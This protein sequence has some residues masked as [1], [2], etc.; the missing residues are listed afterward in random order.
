MSSPSRK[1]SR[2]HKPEVQKK[3]AYIKPN[4]LRVTV[5]R[6]LL[7]LFSADFGP[8]RWTVM[9]GAERSNATLS[10]LAKMTAASQAERTVLVR[11]WSAHYMEAASQTY[12]RS[13][14]F[15]YEQVMFRCRF[16]VRCS[17]KGVYC[18]A[19]QSLLVQ[20]WWDKV[21]THPSVNSKQSWQWFVLPY[22]LSVQFIHRCWCAN[23]VWYWLLFLPVMPLILQQIQR[24]INEN[25]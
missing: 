6:G 24:D 12:A 2:L 14:W 17:C 21:Q 15:D 8:L 9:L 10:E 7:R 3:E 19:T 18:F 25:G 23:A 4:C 16:Q 22:H 1:I 5:N 20:F 11:H 13:S